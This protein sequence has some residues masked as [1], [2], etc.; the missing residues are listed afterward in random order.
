MLPCLDGVVGFPVYQA[1]AAVGGGRLLRSQLSIRDG[2]RAIAARFICWFLNGRR[3]SRD[4][5]AQH[6][7]DDPESVKKLSVGS[8]VLMTVWLVLSLTEAGRVDLWLCS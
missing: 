5:V 2:V 3:L 7:G 1:S 4:V 6:Q 8:V